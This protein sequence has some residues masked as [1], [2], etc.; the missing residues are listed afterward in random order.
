METHESVGGA[1]EDALGDEGRADGGGC[2]R[3]GDS[4]FDVAVDEGGFAD[5]CVW[6]KK[7][8]YLFVVVNG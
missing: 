3:G 5:A 4:V 7:I 8:V 1:V 6:E 2:C